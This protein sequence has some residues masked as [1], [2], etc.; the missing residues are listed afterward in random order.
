MAKESELYELIWGEPPP[1]RPGAGDE[2]TRAGKRPPAHSAPRAPE[3]VAATGDPVLDRLSAIEQS[4]AELV[5]I[6]R[7]MQASAEFQEMVLISLEALE[8]RM[9]RMEKGLMRSLEYLE[10]RI[11]AVEQLR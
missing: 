11:T 10:S 6:A 3:P 9:K 2:A 7:Q 1:A 8:S 4:M 5:E